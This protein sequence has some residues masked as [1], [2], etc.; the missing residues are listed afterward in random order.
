MDLGIFAVE[1]IEVSVPVL[2]KIP[3]HVVVFIQRSWSLAQQE[4]QLHLC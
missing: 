2:K 3:E 4:I 1:L